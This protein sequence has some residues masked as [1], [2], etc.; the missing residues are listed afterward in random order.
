MTFLE[1]PMYLVIIFLIHTLI[2][3]TFISLS[4]FKIFYFPTKII[5]L[6][7]KERLIVEEK[8]YTE[9]EIERN[10]GLTI[11]SLWLNTTILLILSGILTIVLWVVLPTI[12]PIYYGLSKMF[13]ENNN[14]NSVTF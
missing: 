4:S 13:K 2:N 6:Y 11:F 1:H 3:L 12:I 5:S 7:K 9:L 8:R 14:S 10:Y